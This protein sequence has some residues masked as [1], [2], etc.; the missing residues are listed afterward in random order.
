MLS[1]FGDIE[2]ILSEDLY[3][4]R[5]PIVIGLVVATIAAAWF[6][7]RQGWHRIILRYPAQ[8]AA[9]AVVSIAVLA[10]PVYYMGS[11]LFSGGKTVCEAS[12]IAGASAGSERCAGVAQ[13]AEEPSPVAG[14]TQTDVSDK[15][16]APA[17]TPSAEAEVAAVAQGEFKGA[18]DFHFGR[19]QAL[20]IQTG[21]NEHTLRFEDFE[22]RNGPDLFV[23]LSTDPDGYSDDALELGELKGTKGAFN[24]EVPAGTDVAQYKSAVVWCTDFGV[25]F[26]VAPLA[27]S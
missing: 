24:Y 17:A 10:Y 15:P 4:Y 2:R 18:D 9:I 21:A 22:V 1:I 3:P 23:Y 5:W 11:P 16:T 19:G 14:E 27:G 13:A 25:L 6:A 26:A 7:Y 20:L 8:S 12:P